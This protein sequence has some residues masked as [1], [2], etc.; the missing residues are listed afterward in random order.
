MD[1]ILES[2]RTA[3]AH[4][5]LYQDKVLVIQDGMTF[6]LAVLK[7]S[8]RG[9]KLSNKGLYSIGEKGTEIYVHASVVFNPEGVI[10]GCLNL[11]GEYRDQDA[12]QQVQPAQGEKAR[13][14][15]R[16]IEGLQI[17]SDLEDVCASQPERQ[18]TRVI[19][20]GDGECEMCP[21]YEKYA[22]LKQS[23]PH[24]GFVVRCN[25]P[26]RRQVSVDHQGT[27]KLVSLED[28][29][30]ATPLLGETKI[31]IEGESQ[32]LN[33]RMSRVKLMAP[34]SKKQTISSVEVSCILASVVNDSG[35]KW[36]LISSEGS[37]Q[38]TVDEAELIIDHYSKRWRIQEF[39]ST[40]ET[41]S[42]IKQAYCFNDLKD[43]I[44]SLG[45]DAITAY[46]IAQLG[47]MAAHEP[48]N[49][50]IAQL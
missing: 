44:K 37:A 8:I 21:Y 50:S 43:F 23:S 38:P 41:N 34:Q 35:K 10:Q 11:D 9:K 40:L 28:H 19:H 39:F 6:D 36:L 20:V 17:A 14:S 13:E 5:C 27:S 33:L 22:K 16:W 45:F 25:K 1:D 48:D 7:R 26:Y 47:H 4:C 15:Y 12:D 30:E 3:T 29:M 32:I 42:Q 31:F 46:R 2:H 49:K 24:L 18:P